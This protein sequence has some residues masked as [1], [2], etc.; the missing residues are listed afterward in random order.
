MNASSE[1]DLT[2]IRGIGPVTQA[3]LNEKGVF[4]LRQV[5][6]MTGQKLVELLENSTAATGLNNP[7][8]W[9]QQALDLLGMTEAELGIDVLEQVN[10]LNASASLFNQGNAEVAKTKQSQTQEN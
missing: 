1:D 9:P 7:D 10:E 4:S 5:A 3:R 6:S 8:T 2:V